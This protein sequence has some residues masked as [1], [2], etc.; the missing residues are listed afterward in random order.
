MNAGSGRHL[1]KLYRN[2]PDC[3]AP[4]NSATFTGPPRLIESPV[5]SRT[6]AMSKKSVADILDKIEALDYEDRLRLNKELARRFK[7]EWKSETTSAGKSA[8]TAAASHK[9]QS[10]ASLNAAAMAGEKRN[11]F[12]TMNSATL[13]PPSRRGR[14]DAPS[15]WKSAA[16]A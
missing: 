14:D 1:L 16:R 13:T 11:R 10:I 2:C 4:R 5:P 8:R 7:N 12:K 3:R 15:V 9:P 6:P